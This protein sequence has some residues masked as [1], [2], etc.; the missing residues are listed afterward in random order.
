P[1]YFPLAVGDDDPGLWQIA[2][3][4]VTFNNQVV[5]QP[6]TAVIDSGT[7]NIYIPPSQASALYATIPNS[8]P[9]PD[10]RHY[11]FPCSSTPTVGL[12]FS[13]STTVFNIQ[14][15]QFNLGEMEEGSDMCVGAVLSSGSE[16]GVAL[17][18]DAFMSSWYSIFDY[19]NMAVGFAQAV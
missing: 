11:L 9:D 7:S 10:G 18:G 14:A 15:S 1:E 17:V 5:T 8:T 6:L 4:G 16:D 3:D 2:S 13:G 12:S 19:G